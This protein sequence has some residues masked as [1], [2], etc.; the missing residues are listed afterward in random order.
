M[1]FPSELVEA[2]R[3]AQRCLLSHPRRR[4]AGEIVLFVDRKP[5]QR[6]L[7]CIVRHP[8]WLL[9]LMRSVPQVHRQMQVTATASNLPGCLWLGRSV[10][11]T[12]CPT[13]GSPS[14]QNLTWTKSSTPPWSGEMKPNPLSG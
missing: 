9:R 14:T 11:D 1:P 5:H 6:A 7:E 3:G 13:R 12:R 8:P 10:N 4:R 2:A